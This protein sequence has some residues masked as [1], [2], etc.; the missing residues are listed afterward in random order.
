MNTTKTLSVIALALL[1]TACGGG[2]PHPVAITL[3]SDQPKDTALPS[4]AHHSQL[5]LPIGNHWN[6]WQCREGS[7]D[8]RYPDSSKQSLQLRYMS[9]EHTL[10]QRPGDNPA[11]YE[12]G[13]IAFSSPAAVHNPYARQPLPNPQPNSPLPRRTRSARSGGG[14]EQS[15]MNQ[16]SGF[17]IVCRPPPTLLLRKQYLSLRELC[18]SPKE[19]GSL[20]EL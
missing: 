7:F 4:P 20:V 19:R 9:G 10:E 17:S 2:K 16:S 12:N 11:T 14:G 8:T 1:L 15:L 3:E 13:Q 5:K 6:T 18:Q